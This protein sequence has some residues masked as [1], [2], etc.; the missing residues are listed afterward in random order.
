MGTKSRWTAAVLVA[1]IGIAA[2]GCTPPTSG[3]TADAVAPVIASVDVTPSSTTPGTTVT[4]SAAITDNKAVGT[5]IFSVYVPTVTYI[6]C[7][8]GNQATRTSGTA[9]DGVWSRTC[10]LPASMNSGD[11]VVA[12]L[13]QDVYGNLANTATSPTATLTITGGTNDLDPPVTSS[14]SATPSTVARGQTTVISADITDATGTADVALQ[15]LGPTSVVACYAG[16]SATLTSGTPQ[17]GTWSVNCYVPGTTT[18]A[19]YQIT[20]IARDALGNITNPATSPN[21]TLTVT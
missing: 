14:L 19:V 13:A 15:I 4:L 10:T 17:D 11:Y 16:N 12:V 8:G 5:V 21:I 1:V 9:A 6:S 18:P 20:P 7:V 2:V 3:G